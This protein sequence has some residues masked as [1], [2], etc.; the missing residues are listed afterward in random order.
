MTQYDIF[1]IIFT[2]RHKYVMIPNLRVRNEQ[3]IEFVFRDFVKG[4]MSPFS[5][6]W[7]LLFIFNDR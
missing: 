7:N 4:Y 6:S 5:H 3:M 1:I 2:C